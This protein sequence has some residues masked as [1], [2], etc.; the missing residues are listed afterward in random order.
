MDVLAKWI[1]AEDAMSDIHGARPFLFSLGHG[2][3]RFEHPQKLLAIVGALLIDPRFITALHELTT[4]ERDGLLIRIDALV[5]LAFSPRGFGLGDQ[6]IEFV[7][8]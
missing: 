1:V 5:E 2:G 7:G 4:I 6:S 3:Q 8:V